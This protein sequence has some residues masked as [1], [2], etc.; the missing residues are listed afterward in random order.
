MQTVTYYVDPYSG[1]QAKVVYKGK[2]IPYKYQPYT[3]YKR[4]TYTP[5][6]ANPIAAQSLK[7]EYRYGKP[8][9][10][11]LTTITPSPA[12]YPS[13][14]YSLHPTPIAPIK[15]TLSN[16]GVGITQPRYR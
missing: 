10:S 2:A 14:T 5:A 1:Y 11:A 3:P 16:Y 8:Y 12:T 9:N 7:T 4:P 15:P 13:N 6:V